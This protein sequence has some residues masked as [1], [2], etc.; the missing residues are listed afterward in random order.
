MMPSPLTSIFPAMVG[1]A[2]A[3][4]VPSGFA[5]DVDLI[6]GHEART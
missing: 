1:G 5:V 2:E 3:V 6:V 4:S